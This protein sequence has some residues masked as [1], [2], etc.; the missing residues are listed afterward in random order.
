MTA[1]D[2][3]E[4]GPEVT[5]ARIELTSPAGTRH[6]TARL[7]DGLAIA[8][9]TGAPIRVADAVMD[10]LAVPM[11]ASRAGSLPDQTVR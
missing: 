8:I 3:D 9:T 2:I 4:L 7:P 5:A 6:V 10:R 11:G 1:V